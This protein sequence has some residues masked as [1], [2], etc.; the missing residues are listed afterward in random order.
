MAKN[1][2]NKDLIPAESMAV[3]VGFETAAGFALLQR[4]ASLFAASNIVPKEYQ[5]N[6]ANCVIAIDMA[7]RMGANPLMVMQNLYVVYGRPSWSAQFLIATMNQTKRYT[8]LRYEFVGTKGKDDWGCYA[9][10]T[11]LETGKELKGTL[12]TID[13]AKKEGWYEKSGS[14]WKTIPE[15]MLQYR[16]ASWFIRAYCPE[17]AMGLHTVDEV[18]DA[19]DMHPDGS[20]AFVIEDM[21]EAPAPEFGKGGAEGLK[22]H[23]AH[24]KGSDSPKTAAQESKERAIAQAKEAREVKQP[25]DD[26]FAD[27]NWPEPG[28]EAAKEL[29]RQLDLEAAESGDK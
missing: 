5:G 25:D 9:Y 27:D 10:A 26:P 21:L 19:I 28:S 20:G 22:A 1:T 4:Q 23:L 16:A 11:E 3:V 18:Q 24:D 8:A 14:K 2:E 7:H 29:S 13:L 12:I 17:I 15:L 6:V